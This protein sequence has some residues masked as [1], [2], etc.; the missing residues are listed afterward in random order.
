MKHGTLTGYIHHACRC[1]ACRA[2][3][4]SHRKAQRAR[5]K[6]QGLCLECPEPAE[7]G[8]ARCSHHLGEA[9]DRARLKERSRREQS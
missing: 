7:P 4:T 9:A 2:A 5:H 1:D 6:A 3:N 8:A